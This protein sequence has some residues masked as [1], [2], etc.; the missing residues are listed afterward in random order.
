MD[1]ASLYLEKFK[2]FGF[3]DQ[4]LKEALISV[5]EA[6][7][8]ALITKESIDINEGTVRINVS[9]SLKSELYLHKDKIQREVIEKIG[10]EKQLHKLL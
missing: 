3:K 6:N 4:I 8:G 7:F 9:G 10:D 5:V 1:H 2:E